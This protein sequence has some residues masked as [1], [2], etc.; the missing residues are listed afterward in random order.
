[1]NNVRYTLNPNAYAKVEVPSQKKEKTRVGKWADSNDSIERVYWDI[2]DV[3]RMLNTPKSTIRYY[4]YKY[5]ICA[6]RSLGGHRKFTD[7][8]IQLMRVIIENKDFLTHEGILAMIQGR[9][10][11]LVGKWGD[12]IEG[13]TT[14]TS[15]PPGA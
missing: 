11:I 2:G 6:G 5:D 7:K 10:K 3:A 8:D 15:Q 12:P 1:M 4:D 13:A 9:I 14:S